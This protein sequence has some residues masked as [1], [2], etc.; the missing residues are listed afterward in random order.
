MA[1]YVLKSKKAAIDYNVN[2]FINCCGYS[3]LYGITLNIANSYGEWVNIAY[4]PDNKELLA[5]HN[6]EE[7]WKE[8]YKYITTEAPEFYN[9]YTKNINYGRIVL[10]DSPSSLYFTKWFAHYNDLPSTGGYVPNPAHSGLTC[11]EMWW[12]D[13]TEPV[14]KSYTDYKQ[15]VG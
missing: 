10:T 7:A 6:T 1:H 15:Y 3:I 9:S 13:L 12:I 4:L 8:F 14:Q 11:I 2:T 5:E